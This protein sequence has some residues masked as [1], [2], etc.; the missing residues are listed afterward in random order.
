MD[1]RENPTKTIENRA[2]G[3][4]DRSGS[5]ARHLKVISNHLESLPSRSGSIPRVLGSR[6]TPF[7]KVA[8]QNPTNDHGYCRIIITNLHEFA[9]KSSKTLNF[10]KSCNI[11]PTCSR[12]LQ[13]PSPHD[14]LGTCHTFKSVSKSV[15]QSR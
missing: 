1:F 15:S 6:R 2:V 8:I 5:C 10:A 11:L 4:A 13:Y 3:P 14:F 9:K 12:T 7:S